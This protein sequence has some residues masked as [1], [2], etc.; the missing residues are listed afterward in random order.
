MKKLFTLSLALVASITFAS[1]TIFKNVLID[2]LCY[3]LDDETLTATLVN[4]KEAY[5]SLTSVIMPETVEY[6]E[7]TFDVTAIAD[8]AF[9]YTY[10]EG[11][12]QFV[13]GNKVQTIGMDAFI[14]CKSVKSFVIPNSVKTIGVEAFLRCD[15]LTTVTIGDG[16]EY[17]GQSAFFECD[18]LSSVTFGNCNPVFSTRVFEGCT[19]LPEVDGIRYAGD[20]LV[21]VIDR[22]QTTYTI[23]PNTRWIGSRAFVNCKSM[24]SIVL[25]ES[26]RFIGDNAFYECEKLQTVNIPDG[27]TYIGFGAFH[28]C[29]DLESVVLP[30]GLTYIG[31]Q[32][33]SS[34]TA[35]THLEVPSTVTYIGKEAFAY[36]SNLSSIV[37]HCTM[38]TLR[39]GTLENCTSLDTVILPQGVK[40]IDRFAFSDCT[41]LAHVKMSEGLISIEQDAFSGCTSLAEVELPATLDTIAPY[42]FSRSAAGSIT[43]KALTPPRVDADAFTYMKT[44]LRIL[45]VPEESV[46]AY[47]A[48]NVWKNFYLIL[49]IAEDETKFAGWTKYDNA[50]YDDSFGFWGEP[51]NWGIMIPT[52]SIRGNKL[53]QVALFETRTNKSEITLSVVSGGATPASGQ[54]LHTESFMPVGE[55][56]HIITFENPIVI[57][58][59]QNLWIYFSEGTDELPAAMD[60][61]A[62]NPNAMWIGAYDMWMNTDWSE[63]PCAFM[64][65]AN[66]SGTEDMENVSATIG[67]SSKFLRN[68]QLFILRAV[69]DRDVQI[70]NAQG[71]RVE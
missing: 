64:I 31:D 12:T 54:L 32:A 37:L 6:N 65:R 13:I 25:P 2:G 62:S 52:D 4:N 46:D 71:A 30:E 51:F 18:N 45:R 66:I 43:C 33:F 60:Y 49:P 55:G 16:V 21:Q 70:F 41:A 57:D 35:F 28:L 61:T 63:H 7:Q 38:D 56:Y 27:V 1:A 40:C 42:A 67:K 20:Y 69:S 23:Q 14:G 17:I 39:H 68:G 15:A 47:K 53:T 5:K 10:D 19:S 48:A 36:E 22:S 8:F 44:M 29:Y 26:V 50:H 11:I 58:P 24:T 3:D 9:G 59:T 34:C